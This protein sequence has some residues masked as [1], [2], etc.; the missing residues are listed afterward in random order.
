MSNRNSNYLVFKTFDLAMEKN[1]GATPIFH[2][3]RG[4][5]YTL[6]SF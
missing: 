3:D 2:S 1:L 4:F 5:Q 6:Y